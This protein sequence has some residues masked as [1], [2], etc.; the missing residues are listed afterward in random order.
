M[1][2]DH[3]WV[4]ISVKGADENRLIFLDIGIFGQYTAAESGRFFP[5]AC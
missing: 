4:D 1:A 2:P 3:T 5:A